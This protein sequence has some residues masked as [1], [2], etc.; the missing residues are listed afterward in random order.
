MMA[1]RPTWELRAIIKALSLHPWLNSPE[2]NQ[3][4]ADAK[5]ELTTRTKTHA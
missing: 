1:N 5:A 3:R 2:E 4:L